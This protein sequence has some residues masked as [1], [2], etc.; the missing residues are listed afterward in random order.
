MNT[1]RVLRPPRHETLRV[2]GLDLHLTR[3]GPQP[4]DSAA[5]VFLLHG[6][7]DTGDTFQFM[8]D[9]FGGDWPLVA[10][11]WRGFGRSE[12]ARHGY[13]FPDYLADLDAL[14][15]R[16][17]PRVPARIV[18]HS[19]GGNIAGLYAGLR[20]DR[21]RCV[22][23]LEGFGM[24]RT[25]PDQAP[26]QLRKWLDQ[27]KTAPTLKDYESF[28]QLASIILSRYPRF[29]EARSMFV[30]QAW[31]RLEADGRVHLLGDARH[32]WVN[33][34]LYRREEAEACWRGIRAP[35]LMLLGEQSEYLP[36][37][38]ADGTDSGFRAVIAGIEIIRIA[39][40]GH[41]LHIERPDLVAPL[42]ESFLSGH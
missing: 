8:V 21:V 27:V 11:D 38:G 33:P 5:P 10:L 29:T 1:Y 39:D 2:R 36:R 42:V 41:M 20:P 35:M 34:V 26:A 13:W 6:W 40:T 4:S 18:G 16:L 12:W 17:S 30:A 14:L 37:L 3:W 7:A 23:N 24:P 25:T 19:M 32:R 15:E 28:E 22:V 31:G 9:A